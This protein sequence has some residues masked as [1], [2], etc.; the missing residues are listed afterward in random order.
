MS[1][2][3]TEQAPAA[4][5]EVLSKSEAVILK[6]KKAIVGGVIAIIVLIVG[7]ILYNTHIVA[8]A[9]QEAAEALFPAESLFTQ[10]SYQEAVDGDGVNL[11]LLAVAEEYSGTTSGNL[12]N[13][14]AGMALAQLGRYEEAIP[15]LEAFDGDD[16][17]VA[18]AAL[19]TLGNCY[20][21]TGN[22]DKAIS[23]FLDAA[24]EADNKTLSPYYLM[25]AA[26]MHEQAGNASKALKLYEEIKEKYP[27][28]AQGRE[29]EKYIN[30]IK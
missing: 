29:I 4:I 3:Q 1:T 21:Q 26:L 30:R 14:Y 10:G 2:K 5:E 28:S 11:G 15:Y 19:G 25:Q 17:M 7:G 20:A 12:A 16:Q 23:C 8:P 18:P 6:Y 13:A 27:A 24:S 22:N 9:E